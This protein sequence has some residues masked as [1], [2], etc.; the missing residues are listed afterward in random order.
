MEIYMKF[1][2]VFFCLMV[3]LIIVNS[4]LLQATSAPWPKSPNYGRSGSPTP[5]WRPR[6]PERPFPC[7]D[8]AASIRHF[9]SC[10]ATGSTDALSSSEAAVNV[11][12]PQL[13][14]E[15][16]NKLKINIGKLNE[17]INQHKQQLRNN[18]QGAFEDILFVMAQISLIKVEIKKY[19]DELIKESHKCCKN[20]DSF[21]SWLKKADDALKTEI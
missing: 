7:P 18:P 10:K 14:D 4:A 6:S 21:Y 11:S 9:D 8:A 15:A 2:Q 17:L 3:L 19:H 13:I 16:I 1:K 12:V 5:G 20:L